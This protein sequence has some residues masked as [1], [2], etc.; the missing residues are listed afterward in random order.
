MTMGTVAAGTAVPAR[1]VR[2]TT[3]PD[4]AE[5]AKVSSA[6]VEE[7]VADG[8]TSGE[9]VAVRLRG[10]E[11]EGEAVIITRVLM[12]LWRGRTRAGLS[13]RCLM[14]I[15][16]RYHSS[17]RED[18]SSRHS[19]RFRKV[20]QRTIISH[21]RGSIR[22]RISNSSS[23]V[24]GRRRS[25]VLRRH[26]NKDRGGQLEVGVMVLVVRISRITTRRGTILGV[27]SW[28]TVVWRHQ[29]KRS[30][31]RSSKRERAAFWK[32]VVVTLQVRT[33]HQEPRHI[34]HRRKDSYLQRSKSATVD[35][36]TRAL[37]LLTLRNCKFLSDRKA[38]RISSDSKKPNRMAR[39]RLNIVRPSK[40]ARL[41]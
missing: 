38:Q 1:R 22:R 17:S 32:E 41:I 12:M 19:R 25:R 14:R 37:L 3:T 36:W 2:D 18:S 26:S 23:M 27:N 33:S 21:N 7:V 9:A 30:L 6:A 40:S 29:V 15:I 16:R 4:A 11:V 34:G 31:Q 24:V 35:L 8:A 5:A 10:R 13:S 39:A 20:R 28:H